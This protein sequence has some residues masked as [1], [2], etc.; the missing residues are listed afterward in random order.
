MLNRF[1]GAVLCGILL[2][3]IAGT[4]IAQDEDSFFREQVVSKR[5]AVILSA[6]FPGLGQM[7]QGQKVRGV[8]MFLGEAVSLVL[9]INA[10]ENYKTKQNL[11][12]RDMGT[13]N[14]MAMT[15]GSSDNSARIMFNDLKDQSDELDNLNT[16]RNTA[17]IVAAGVYAYNLFDAVFLSS[18]TTESRRASFDSKKLVVRSAMIDRN[19]GIMLSK[20]F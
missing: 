12:D 17:L 11:Y 6:L 3:G 13:Y 10:N 7:T 14:A 18:S 16:M 20:R 2:L 8:T 9:F 1:I 4:A 5:D 19:P 15:Q